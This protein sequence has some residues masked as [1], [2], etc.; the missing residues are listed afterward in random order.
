LIR[1]LS[2]TPSRRSLNCERPSAEASSVEY[3][4]YAIAADDPGQVLGPLAL[5]LLD[6]GVEVLYAPALD[7]AALLT[8]Q[9]ARRV[10][11]VLLPASALGADTTKLPRLFGLPAARLLP[12]AET[13]D[14]LSAWA[15]CG[16]RLAIRQPCGDAD[17]RFAVQVALAYDDQGEFR[18]DLRAPID[19]NGELIEVRPGGERRAQARLVDISAGGAY[20]AVD[21]PIEP[22]R[23]AELILPELLGGPRVEIESVFAWRRRED[24]RGTRP[25]GM[26]VMFIQPD[27]TLRSACRAYV[28]SQI[29][30][31]ELAKPE[32]R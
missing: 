3:Q 11:A 17:L 7:E 9:E 1:A 27:L 16:A 29:A 8:R 25:T 10:G 13:A 24:S 23:R 30:R 12:V 20:L 31:F 4:R 28:R 26:G 14:D 19:A 6:L 2:P 32:P 18:V 15:Q 22:G 21:D 5:R